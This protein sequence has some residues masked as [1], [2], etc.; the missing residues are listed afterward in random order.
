MVERL[1]GAPI[2]FFF[3]GISF[4]LCPRAVPAREAE[5]LPYRQTN[6]REATGLPY[7][8]QPLYS[9]SIVAGG[10]LDMS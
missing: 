5:S 9:H 3:I 2:E 10:L 1:N 8:I 4:L 7:R 6:A